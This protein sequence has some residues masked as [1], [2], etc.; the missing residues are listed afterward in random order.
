[1]SRTKTALTITLGGWV[2]RVLVLCNNLIL[3][4]IIILAVGVENYGYWL[5]SGGV[6]AWLSVMDAG[7]AP[8]I[9]QRVA[10]HA[11]Q[12]DRKTADTYFTHGLAAYGVV[13]FLILATTFPLGRFLPGFLGVD[14]AYNMDFIYAI[15]LAGLSVAMGLLIIVVESYY[16]AIQRARLVVVATALAQIILFGSTLLLLKQDLGVVAIAGGLVLSRSFLV[17]CLVCGLL[18]RYE[19]SFLGQFRLKKAIIKDYLSTTPI[20]VFARLGGQSTAKIEPLILVL[21]ISPQVA[22]GYAIAKKMIEILLGFSNTIRGA[23]APGFSHFLGEKGPQEAGILLT[24]VLQLCLAPVLIM[25]AIY[26]TT[27]EIFVATWIP[28]QWIPAFFVIMLLGLEAIIGSVSQTVVQLVGACG[29]IRYS[30]LAIFFEAVIR[31]ALMYVF[32]SYSGYEILPMACILS[33]LL[34]LW[35][36]W[37]RLRKNVKLPRINHTSISLSLIACGCFFAVLAWYSNSTTINP[38]WFNLC[39]TAATSGGLAA[40]FSILAFP[41]FRERLLAKLAKHMLVLKGTKENSKH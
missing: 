34:L 13:A 2:S 39:V 41:E 37:A 23:I 31:I 6:L 17:L 25:V 16:Y 14:G 26:I 4:P 12:G 5:A 28:G 33:S 21:F 15:W 10:F 32:L 40:L 24:K 3:I 36:A 8:L 19:R 11:G 20:I 27:N 38:S 7:I 22:T 30:S 18:G 1:M 29:D 35:L 9:R